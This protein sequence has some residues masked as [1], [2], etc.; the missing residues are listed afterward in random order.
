MWWKAQKI[1]E[2]LLQNPLT[3]SRYGY[4]I[5]TQKRKGEHE[6]DRNEIFRNRGW[7]T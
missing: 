6:N 4:I 2:K 7:Y 5:K 1:F 3:L